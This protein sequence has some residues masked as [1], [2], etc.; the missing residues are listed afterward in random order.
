MSRALRTGLTLVALGGCGD[1]LAPTIHVVAEGARWMA[2]RPAPDAAWQRLDGDD[3]RFEARGVFDVAVVCREDVGN[4]FSLRAT[5]DDALTYDEH[6]CRHRGGVQPRFDITGEADVIFVGASASYLPSIVGGDIAPGTYD[7]V[8][9]ALSADPPQ[10]IERIQ[11]VRDVVV[12]GTATIP[13]DIAGLG[14]PPATATFTVDGEPP[15]YAYVSGIT[16]N[17]TWFSLSGRGHVVLPV[18]LTRPSDRQLA[19]VYRGGAWADVPVH[20][21]ENDI[22]MPPEPVE[23]TF[24]APAPPAAAHA[25]VTWRSPVAWRTVTLGVAQLTTTGAGLPRWQVVAFPGAF[26]AGDGGTSWTVELPVPELAGWQASWL[27]DLARPHVVYA[28][29][30]RPRPD[31]GRGGIT[32]SEQRDSTSP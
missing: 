9:L 23:T 28:T 32:M 16:A 26:V 17:G 11:I 12:D 1:D 7:V 21:G 22:A 8:A 24:S 19:R 5:A 14:L 20:A 10:R 18:E 4:G 31:G 27:A 2:V 30:E 13:I 6:L 25:E 15:D 3:V 29:W